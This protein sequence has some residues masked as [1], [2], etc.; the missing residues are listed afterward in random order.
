MAQARR[1]KE[2]GGG[3]DIVGDR[4][5]GQRQSVTP[6][7]MTAPVDAAGAEGPFERILLASEGRPIP[8]AAIERV[9][10]LARRSGASVRVF[11]IARVH[12]TAYGFPSPGLLPTKAEWAQQRDLVAK[13]V[14][15]LRRKGIE[16][17]GQVIGTRKST[18][19]ICEEATL[20]ECDAIVMAADPDRN[21]L[22]GDLIWS[23]EPQRVRRRAKVPVFLVADG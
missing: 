1:R 10:Q 23:Q 8:D 9:V 13:A 22:I 17:K 19:R 15:Q 2:R 16:A 5:P 18:K 12:G 7:S 20:S 4:R 14:K 21:R 6:A 3:R 11:S